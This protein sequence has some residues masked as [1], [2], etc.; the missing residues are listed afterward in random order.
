M[1][2]LNAPHILRQYQQ[3]A[4]TTFVTTFFL[5]WSTRYIRVFLHHKGLSGNF[6]IWE[7]KKKNKI[8]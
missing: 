5:I 4:Q 1:V 2:S 3:R 7:I 6:Q 8:G